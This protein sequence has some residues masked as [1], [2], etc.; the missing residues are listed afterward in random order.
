M[1]FH[2][3]MVSTLDFES[4][5]PSSNLGGTFFIFLYVLKCIVQSDFR[6]VTYQKCKEKNTSVEPDSNQRP[7]DF[8][9]TPST[10]HRSTN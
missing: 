4:S 10:V 1:G 9:F 5:D 6:F 3:V 8:S 2:G 7:M